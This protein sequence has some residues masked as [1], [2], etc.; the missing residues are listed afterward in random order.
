MDDDDTTPQQARESL[1]W[2]QRVLIGGQVLLAAFIAVPAFVVIYTTTTHLVDPWFGKYSW[3]VPV[4]IEVVLAYLFLNGLFLATRQK[5]GGVLRG[6]SMAVVAALSITVQ[7]YAGRSAVPDL[8]GH[9][10]VIVG[11]FVVMLCGKQTIVLWRGD[12]VRHD[13]LSFGEIALHPFRSAGLLWWMS[14]WGEPSKAVA[15]RRHRA[16]L[17]ART[18]AKASEDVGR[19]PVLWK[20]RLPDTLAEDF[21][22]GLFPDAVQEAIDAGE[23]TWRPLLRK[24]VQRELALL[25]PDTVE[26][27]E[28]DAPLT[29]ENILAGI[30][31]EA[32]RDMFRDILEDTVR[33]TVRDTVED[34]AG[35]MFRAALEDSDPDALRDMLRDIIGITDD[36]DDDEDETGK[37][38]GERRSSWPLAKSVDKQVLI[39]RIVTEINKWHAKGETRNLPALGLDALLEVRMNRT[40]AKKLIEEAYA[41]R[42]TREEAAA[43]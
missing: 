43:Q 14:S 7:V 35:D 31:P 38:G 1:T 27:T 11:F 16:L 19:V 4:T 23:S 30:D 10:A 37:G 36:E 42:D 20:R 22:Y 3:V 6:V 15:L 9:L 2:W 32:V 12:K 29:P 34:S 40:T 33:S 25:D 13:R 28:A 39:R 41:S 24:H 8:L 21:R 18:I 17:Y 26:D 5:P